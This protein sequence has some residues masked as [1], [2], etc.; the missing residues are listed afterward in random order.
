MDDA[1]YQNLLSRVDN[2]IVSDE[3]PVEE[4]GWHKVAVYFSGAWDLV[5]STGVYAATMMGECV[6]ATREK[7]DD[8][9]ASHSGGGTG[10][11]SSLQREIR[12]H[13]EGS[14]YTI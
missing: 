7:V 10:L 1:Y 8:Y 3:Q 14:G 5:K 11:S 6:H 12:E 13:D 9:R 4:T 2:A